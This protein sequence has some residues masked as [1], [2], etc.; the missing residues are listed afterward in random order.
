MTLALL[1]SADRIRTDNHPAHL[2]VLDVINMP[3]NT[4]NT[5]YMIIQTRHA[6]A[7][8]PYVARNT[9]SWGYGMLG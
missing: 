2:D 5:F 6:G 1:I 8:A 9:S 4:A 7:Y 3:S